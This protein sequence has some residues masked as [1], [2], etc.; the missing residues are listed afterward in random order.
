MQAPSLQLASPAKINLFLN[1]LER[2]ADGF[3]NLETLMTPLALCDTLAFE[4]RA[5]GFTVECAAPDVPADDRNLVVKAA[6]K[7]AETFHVNKGAHIQIHKQIPAG[8]GMGGGSG[9]AAVTLRALNQLWQ[10]NA[11]MEKLH[12]IAA[13]IGSDVPFFLYNSPALCKGRGEI[14][15]PLKL[16][17]ELGVL[18]VNPG[19]GIPTQWAY[20]AL[21]TERKFAKGENSTPPYPSNAPTL[22]RSNAVPLHDFLSALR[23]HDAPAIQRGLINSLESPCLKKYPLLALLKDALLRHG[24][25]GAMMTGSGSTVFGLTRNKSEA[26][27]LME[28]MRAEFGPTLWM[29]AT[30]TVDATSGNR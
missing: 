23:S 11:P 12:A 20:N 21:A 7:L 15:E 27:V 30:K 28:K 4:E 29:C 24:A 14:V 1:I 6:K 16:G 18:L 19:F 26:A 8:G 3:H 25:L 17:V 10:L 13:Q 22:Q 9:N 2:R 5:S